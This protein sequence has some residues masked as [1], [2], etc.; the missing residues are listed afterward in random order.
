MPRLAS[1]WAYLRVR[2]RLWI[3]IVA[4]TLLFVGLLLLSEAVGLAPFI[5]TRL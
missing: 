5:Y 4:M 2:K 3:P 1:I